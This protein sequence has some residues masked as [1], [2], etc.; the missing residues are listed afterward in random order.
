MNL[1][2]T[3]LRV[4]VHSKKK[5][6]NELENTSICFL[7]ILYLNYIIWEPKNRILCILASNTKKTIL[8]KTILRITIHNEQS[9]WGLILFFINYK[10]KIV[11]E[12]EK[13]ICILC[14]EIFGSYHKGLTERKSDTGRV[15]Y[16]PAIGSVLKKLHWSGSQSSTYVAGFQVFRPSSTDV[17]ATLAR[18]QIESRVAGT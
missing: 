6:K 4:S 18:S 15:K 9:I 1:L 14:N 10:W 13:Q 12:Y 11:K 5:K 17:S 8:R 3:R 2:T 7:L 16:L